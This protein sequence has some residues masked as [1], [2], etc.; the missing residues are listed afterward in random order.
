MAKTNKELKASV[1]SLSLV[2]SASLTLLSSCGEPSGFRELPVQPESKLGLPEETNSYDLPETS[3][4]LEG[5]VIIVD[6]EAGVEFETVDPGSEEAS[7][8]TGNADTVQ[9][10]QEGNYRETFLFG[11]NQSSPLVD[12]LIVMDNSCS[13]ERIIEPTA[14]GFMS[15][16]G[17]DVLPQK[18]LVGVMTTMHADDYDFT[19][20]GIGINRYPGVDLEPGFL[21]LVHRQA[22]IDYKAAAP[23]YSSKW[24][25]LGCEQKWFALDEVSPEGDSC[26]VAAT[27]ASYTCIGAEAGIRAFRQVL[28]KSRQQPLFREG[29][30]VNVIFVSD[31]HDPGTSIDYLKESVPSYSELI[32]LANETHTLAGLKFHALAPDTQC[33]TEGLHDL[34][35]H[36]LSDQSGGKWQNPCYLND[37][38]DFFAGMA[39]ISGIAERAVF[40]LTRKPSSIDA[41]IV[42]GEA[43]QDYRVVNAKTIVIDHL[44]ANERHTVEIRYRS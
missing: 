19:T 35:Y 41:V 5:V 14:A 24:S 7:K 32:A 42:N 17:S 25:M 22:I 6:D 20:T 23:Q 44:S 11:G 39:E 26:L 3:S 30:I 1:A 33:T 18:A 16:V 13:M 31:T 43:I 9:R 21:D 10:D 40:T 29:A 4:D 36:R 34:S 27:Q 12:Y 28:E 38:E 37:Y 2:C 8:N 15:L